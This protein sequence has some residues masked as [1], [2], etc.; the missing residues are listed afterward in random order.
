MANDA[1]SDEA[2]GRIEHDIL[3]CIDTAINGRGVF[4]VL[5]ALARVQVAVAMSSD[6]VTAQVGLI[7]TSKCLESV[8][9]SIAQFC[10]LEAVQPEGL[11]N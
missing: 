10:F 7:A 8:A 6:R 4:D 2:I 11:P 1:P 9:V 5:A 3:A